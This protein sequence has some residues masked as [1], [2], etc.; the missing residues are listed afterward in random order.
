MPCTSGLL[1]SHVAGARWV[2]Q[3]CYLPQHHPQMLE[4]SEVEPLLYFL[5]TQDSLGDVI[6]C[7]ALN[8]HLHSGDSSL[9]TS[10]ESGLVL[11]QCLSWPLLLELQQAVQTHD[12]CNRFS[13]PNL[14]LFHQQP[15]VVGS[16]SS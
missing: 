10:L 16:A 6:Q 15:Y 9:D 8:S 1:P 11:R 12:S 7:R 5:S 4:D 2:L 14:L 13:S 3:E